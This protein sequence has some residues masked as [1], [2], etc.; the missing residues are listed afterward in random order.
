MLVGRENVGKTSILKCL[1]AFLDNPKAMKKKPEKK[2]KNAPNIPLLRCLTASP[3][4]ASQCSG[5]DAYNLSVVCTMTARTAF[6]WD[7]YRP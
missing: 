3:P 7:D 4:R 6:K 1:H 2:K 5:A